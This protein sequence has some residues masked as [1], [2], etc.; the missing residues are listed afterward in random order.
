[1]SLLPCHVPSSRI[2]G[3][4]SIQ[5]SSALSTTV[6][7]DYP[8]LQSLR[9]CHSGPVTA[10]LCILAILSSSRLRVS[11]GGGG[12]VSLRPILSPV[13]GL[14]REPKRAGIRQVRQQCQIFSPSVQR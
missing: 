10:K 7:P 9:P 13:H 2:A 14:Y 1:M 4:A 5:H 3:H 12:H 8:G 11:E 6:S